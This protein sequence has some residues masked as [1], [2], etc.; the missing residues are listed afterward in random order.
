[1]TMIPLRAVVDKA[2]NGISKFATLCFKK[3]CGTVHALVL[4]LRTAYV[5]LHYQF[6]ITTANGS[7]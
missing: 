6:Y 2:F 3:M 4:D 7:P 1:M 5:S